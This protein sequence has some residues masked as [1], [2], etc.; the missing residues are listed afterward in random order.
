MT[1]GLPHGSRRQALALVLI[2]A[3]ALGLRAVFPLADP[4]WREPI[5]I[6]W[7]DEGVWAHNARNR[8]LWGAWRQDAWNPMFVSPVFTV[9]EY[10][11]FLAAGVGLW[12]AR[13]VSIVAGTLSILALAVGLRNG[14]NRGAAL[15]GALLLGVNYTWVMYSRVALLEA[16]MVALLVAAW[17]CYAGAGSWRG[18]AAAGALA[19]VAFFTKAS[20]VFFLI[21]LGLECLWV[22]LPAWRQGRWRPDAARGIVALATLATLGAGTAAALAV[23]VVPHWSEYAF[24]NLQVY[25]SRR[26]A[27]GVD[28]LI[29]RASWFPVIHGFFSRHWLL[30]AA[31]FGGALPVVCRYGRS[32][33]GERVLVLWLLLGSVEL[34]LH[35]LGNERR[36]VFLIP[37]L[38]G[39]AST[40]LLSGELLPGWLATGSRARL[41]ALLPLLLPGAYVLAGAVTRTVYMPAIS[42]SVRVGAGAALLVAGALL[43]A[44]P[45]LAPRLRQVGWRPAV[46][47]LV[48]A[49]IAAGDLA[50]F[51]RWAAR[52][53]SR[54]YEA[55]LAVGRRLPAGA[56]VQGKLANGLALDNRI[57]PLFIGPGFG[58]YADRHQRHDVKWILTYDRPW[59]G[60][61]G[62]VIRE[63]LASQPGWAVVLELPVAETPAGDDRAVLIR[64]PVIAG[65][66]VT[67]PAGREAAP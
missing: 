57:R 14:S 9:L 26:S 3:A 32:T 21:G 51:A 2:V 48:V 47:W 20:A 40:F 62:A 53:T 28:A 45:R 31:A 16:T 52:H 43:A 50:H 39:L 4:P 7:H 10:V 58:N 6:T 13:L 36:Y 25:G 27:M 8:A 29:D 67:G 35:D 42:P 49:V 66:L 54:N 1:P 38:A 64:K 17:A 30:A 59:L 56:L 19:L 63:V 12:Q 60:Y 24:Y 41:A 61:E 44:W 46:A 11:S 33:P 15:A 18:G 5:G 65:G 22:L 37:A 23:F 34:V 55:S